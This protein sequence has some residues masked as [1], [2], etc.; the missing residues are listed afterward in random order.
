VKPVEMKRLAIARFFGRKRDE[1]DI[2]I[3]SSNDIQKIGETVKTIIRPNENSYLTQVDRIRTLQGDKTK[4]FQIVH[5]FRAYQQMNNMGKI[6]ETVDDVPLYNV[7][8]DLNPDVPMIDPNERRT[9]V[10][11][12]NDPGEGK[13][14][15]LPRSS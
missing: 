11:S 7:V 10:E 8:V 14:P 13:L 12:S 2:E 1:R 15:T 9:A 3:F 5:V 6:V 4:D